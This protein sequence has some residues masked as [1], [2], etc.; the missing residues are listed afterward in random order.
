MDNTN[1]TK[2]N[3]Q[4][5]VPTEVIIHYIVR[6]YRRMYKLHDSVRDKLH[7][8]QAEIKKLKMQLEVAEKGITK[9]E[10]ATLRARIV[11]L[12]NKLD[13]EKK[14]RI[15]AVN[16]HNKLL[17]RFKNIKNVFDNLPQITEIINEDY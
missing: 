6:D 2:V 10:L 3:P 17:Q 11:N 1:N 14:H 4:K 15:N 9:N 5:D 8:Q 7:E 13:N 12:E 16:R